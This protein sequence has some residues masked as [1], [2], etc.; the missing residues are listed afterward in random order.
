MCRSITAT[1]RIRFQPV[2]IYNRLTFSRPAFSDS[3]ALISR[4]WG[5]IRFHHPHLHPINP[6]RFPISTKLDHTSRY[7]LLSLHRQP[8]KIL[9]R[10]HR[11]ARTPLNPWDSSHGYHQ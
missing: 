1:N 7:L 2:T 4:Y 8:L 10:Y 9:T 3:S 11:L 6:T 5:L